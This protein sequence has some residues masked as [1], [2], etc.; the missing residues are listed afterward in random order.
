MS[1]VASKDFDPLLDRLVDNRYLVLSKIASGGMATVYL[2]QD[3]RLDREIALKVM[4]AHLAQGASGANFITR[5]HR[6]ARA[7]AGL[8]HP[9]LV[10]IYDQGVDGDISYLAMEYVAGQNLRAILVKESTLKVARALD[11]TSQVLAALAAAHNNGLVHRD[12]KPE[13]VLINSQ[14]RVKLADFGLARAVSEVTSTTTGTLFGTVAYLSPELITS[15]FG[16]TRSDLY[17][18]GIMLYEMISGR[19]A[20]TG[21]SPI[22]V[23]FQHANSD[24]PPLSTVL[25]WLDPQLDSFV[26]SLINRAPDKRP[27]DAAAALE[28]LRPIISA[29]SPKDL[30]RRAVPLPC[31]PA[32]DNDQASP[33]TGDPVVAA[34]NTS[35]QDSA[36]WTESPAPLQPAKRPTSQG[37]NFQSQHTQALS[38]KSGSTTALPIE[39]VRALTAKNFDTKTQ[40]PTGSKKAVPPKRSGAKPKER[41][42]PKKRRGKFVAVW[43]VVLMILGGGAYGGLYWWNNAGP[44]SYTLVPYDLIDVPIDDALDKFANIEL[45]TKVTKAY[46][47]VVAEGNTVASDPA[48]GLRVRKDSFVTLT[49]SLGIE[50]HEVPS[51]LVGQNAD[52]VVEAL[53]LAGFSEVKQTRTFATGTTKDVVLQLS[54]EQGQSLPHN[55]EILVTISDGP[56]PVT[57]P[58]VTGDTEVE[59]TQKLQSLDISVTVETAYN[60][61]VPQGAVISQSPESQ[62]DAYRGDSATITVSLGPEMVKVPGVTGKSER[63]AKSELEDLGFQVKTDYYLEGF[64]GLVR[65]QEPNA[66]T[67]LPKGSL[68]TIT[69]F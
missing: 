60:D 37:R 50:H 51:D 66:G 1:N 35:N 7:S 18:I 20:V 53:R 22:H 62:A 58:N 8:A 55:T 4:H 57:I 32:W 54:V 3:Q 14:D 61:S 19:P 29:L 63:K 28:Q 41:T 9:G 12:I 25:P 6:E 26:S 15:G 45:E 46:D 38:V 23:A 5:F 43:L 39:Q 64:F 56:E 65:F 44:G 33:A 52:D 10:A 30:A 11:I 24:I 49:E 47:D 31:D 13:N 67:S 40:D 16:D 36:V 59:A 27:H 2:V 48:P 69:I 34:R 42:K 17:A 68:V 21:E